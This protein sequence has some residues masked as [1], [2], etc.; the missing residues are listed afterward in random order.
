M[1]VPV[2]APPHYPPPTN[3]MKASAFVL[4]FVMPVAAIVCGHIALGQIRRS[5]EQGHGLAL[6]GTILGWVFSGFIAL[7]VLVWLSVMLSIFGVVLGTAGSLP[8][9]AFTR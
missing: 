4:A 6:A 5:G 7:M 2:D 3:A 9:G 1:R 8:T